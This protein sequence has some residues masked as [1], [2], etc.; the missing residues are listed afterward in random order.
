MGN[1]YACAVLA[2]IVVLCTLAGVVW[3]HLELG[4][5]P[6]RQLSAVDD[7]QAAID[8]TL[9]RTV[10][11]SRSGVQSP[12]NEAPPSTGFQP[13]TMLTQP[14]VDT[15]NL[16]DG[17]SFG[18]YRGPM[19]RSPLTGAAQRDASPNP[20]WLEPAAAF[21]AIL[22]Q[23]GSS[24]RAYTFA[25]LRL[26]PRTDLQT[27]NR[28]LAGLGASIEGISGEYA[29]VRVPADRT[30]LEAIGGLPGV[31]GLGAVPPGIK[32][33][34]AFVQEMRARS[35]GELVPVYVTLMTADLS[36]E[37]RQALAE[38]G[39]VVGAYDPDLRSYTVNLPAAALA[40][41]LAADYVLSVEPVPVVTANHG[42]AV[43]VMGVDGFRDY[44]ASQQH[45]TGITGSG[46]AVGV[47]DT[48]L[49][50]SHM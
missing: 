24:G 50:T 35:A 16:P 46:I 48:G 20:E 19:Q 23:A 38:L 45:F 36:G 27:L 25:V 2:A 37:W 13:P 17:Y 7:E 43:A 8:R 41:V 44:V 1:Q 12:P 47:L 28:S 49:N 18:T 10:R 42:S 5:D 30:R 26:Q 32:A 39:L 40:R 29:R 4:G 3:R 22:D 34:A 14:G 31:L 9:E 21:G 11:E 33:G 15:E 6:P